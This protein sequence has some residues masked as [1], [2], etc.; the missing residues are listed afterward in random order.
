MEAQMINFTAK[1]GLEYE[2]RP[3]ENDWVKT[4]PCAGQK[5]FELEEEYL[6]KDDAW[7]SWKCPKC[8]TCRDIVTMYKNTLRLKDNGQ[9]PT[10]NATIQG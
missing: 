10:N 4:K 8:G 1:C 2:V 7:I 6:E 3:G 5:T 9:T